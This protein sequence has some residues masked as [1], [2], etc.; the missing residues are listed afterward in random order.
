MLQLR[1]CWKTNRG[2]GSEP[3]R[4]EGAMRI[5]QGSKMAETAQS[6]SFPE[7]V[8]PIGG[9]KLDSPPLRVFLR[10]AR[11]DDQIPMPKRATGT[12][13]LVAT[14]RYC[15]GEVY[16]HPCSEDNDLLSCHRCHLSTVIPRTIATYSSLGAYFRKAQQRVDDFRAQVG[17]L[18]ANKT[19]HEA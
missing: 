3:A 12:P 19:V 14:H 17:S 6:G 18:A 1:G 8:L 10:T 2:I 5:Q 16:R 13:A 7:I 11:G 15:Y 9:A 4:S